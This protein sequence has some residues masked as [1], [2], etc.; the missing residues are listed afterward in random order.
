MIFRVADGFLV[1]S[2]GY[3]RRVARLMRIRPRPPRSADRLTRKSARPGPPTSTA[4]ASNHEA[5]E[6][7][8]VR[9]DV[10]SSDDDLVDL[11][12]FRLVGTDD[13]GVAVDAQKHRS[14]S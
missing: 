5:S 12:A 14:V 3:L 11:E 4:S 6:P 2:G 7:A 13:E 10:G 9:R 1:V 8:S